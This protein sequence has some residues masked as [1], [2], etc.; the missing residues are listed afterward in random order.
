ML[1]DLLPSCISAQ[2]CCFSH[3]ITNKWKADNGGEMSTVS[4]VSG[5]SYAPSNNHAKIHWGQALNKRKNKNS[6]LNSKKALNQ[7]QMTLL[8][9]IQCKALLESCSSCHPCSANTARDLASVSC[10]VSYLLC[11]PGQVAPF[12]HDLSFPLEYWKRKHP[13]H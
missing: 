9:Q 5:S 2:Y 7:K 11:D 8:S 1:L 10:P 3:L 12:L 6:Q 13:R 4:S